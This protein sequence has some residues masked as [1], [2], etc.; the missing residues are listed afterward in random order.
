VQTEN[1]GDLARLK[2]HVEGFNGAKDEVG[3]IQ[4]RKERNEWHCVYVNGLD[5]QL[6]SPSIMAPGNPPS[7]TRQGQSSLSFSTAESQ[8]DDGEQMALGKAD[9]KRDAFFLRFP[10]KARRYDEKDIP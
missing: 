4:R 10:L 3:A 1:L 7:T 8:A 2:N 6:Q 9:S 5:S